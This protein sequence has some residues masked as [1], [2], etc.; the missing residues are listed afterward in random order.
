VKKRSIG[1][2]LKDTNIALKN[3]PPFPELPADLTAVEQA[4]GWS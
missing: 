1:I 4:L 3:A 2:G